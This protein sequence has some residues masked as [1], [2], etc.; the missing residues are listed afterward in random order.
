M[1]SCSIVRPSDRV[2]RPRCSA[3]VAAGCARVVIG[4]SDPAPW[5]AGNGAQRLRDGGVEGEVL[6]D[7]ACLA[8]LEGW[9]ASL[10]LEKD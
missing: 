10:N 5:V 7:A 1:V 9:V 4:M 6:E 2:E 3:Q 8:L